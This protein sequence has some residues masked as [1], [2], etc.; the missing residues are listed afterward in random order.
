MASAIRA[1][2]QIGRL[3]EGRRK[4]VGLQEVVGTEG[5]VVTMQEIYGFS[6]TGVADDGTVQGNFAATGVRPQFMRRLKAFGLNVT[7]DTFDP[8]KTYQ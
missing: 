2:V 3:T 7:D 6:Q 5:D 1:I 8:R 4:L